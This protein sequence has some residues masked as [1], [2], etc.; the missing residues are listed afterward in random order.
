MRFL[1]G[2]SL[3]LV[4]P[5]CFGSQG[6]AQGVGKTGDPSDQAKFESADGVKL[7]GTFYS[8]NKGAKA[9]CVLLVHDFDLKKGGDSHSDGWD[10]L[11]KELQ[12]KG[13]AVLSFDFR[14]HGRSDSVTAEFWKYRHNQSLRSYNPGRP[15]ETI[16]HADFPPSYYP[17]LIED[18]VAAKAYLD[19]KNDAK[20][21]NDSNLVVIAAGQGA[22]IAAMWMA[23]EFKRIPSAGPGIPPRP[24][25]RPE[26]RDLTCGIFLSISP[27]LAGQG[28]PI[29]QWIKE[30]GKDR[31]VPLAFV[32]GK[33][34]TRGD[35]LALSL[36]KEIVPGYSRDK[37][38]AKKDQKFTVEHGIKGSK[39]TGSQL[40]TRTLDTETWILKNYLE[41]LMDKH[42]LEEWRQHE[43]EK[44]FYYWVFSSGRVLPAKTALMQKVPFPVEMM[45]GSR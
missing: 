35:S 36:V 26:G 6:R 5:L 17:H 3:A 7:R 16:S 13:F 31:K 19:S 23:S 2:L 12:K 34:D 21:L 9:P 44:A 15:K 33:D 4:V 8:S 27:T 45:L 24:D 11:A 10:H 37:P 32:F 25:A 29:R 30:V 43:D 1:L 39:L 14:G 42:G 28:M 41:D 20:D 40:L 22:T 38:P 18:L